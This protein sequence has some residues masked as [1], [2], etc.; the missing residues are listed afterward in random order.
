[1][2]ELYKNSLKFEQGDIIGKSGLEETLERDIRGTDGVS[3]LQ[4]DG[5]FVMRQAFLP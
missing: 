3:F 4:V 2:N 1:L 5:S